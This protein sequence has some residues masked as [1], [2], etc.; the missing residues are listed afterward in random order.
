MRRHA[1]NRE[2][3][4]RRLARIII[5]PLPARV[6][7][8]CLPSQLVKTDILRRMAAGRSHHEHAFSA[9]GPV[10]RQAQRLHPAHRSPD[11]RV[12]P[13][14]AERIE[15]S[16]M[17]AHHVANGDDRET[18]G[19]RLPVVGE[20]GGPGRP[21]A[22]ADHIGADYV[23]TVG[24]DRL[25]RAHH[26]FPPAGLAGQW[27]RAGDI[28]VAGQRMAQQDRVRS[29]LGQRPVGL[30]GDLDTRQYAPAIERQRSGQDQRSRACIQIG[31]CSETIKPCLYPLA[32][33]LSKGGFSFM[34]RS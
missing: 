4:V 8:D 31:P 25:A 24:V 28:L 6:G 13:F 30:I 22:A 27:M 3:T 9:F 19:I 7:H 33:R 14:D 17:R 16:H 12:Q 29:V 2:A 34:R 10:R 5:A 26:T 21:H 11:H 1:R 32:C 20:A 15:Q 18:H 23:E